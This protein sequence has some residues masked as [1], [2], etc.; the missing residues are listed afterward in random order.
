MLWRAA[1][2]FNRVTLSYHSDYDALD[3]GA[4]VAAE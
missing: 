2:C 4:H 1:H 3:V